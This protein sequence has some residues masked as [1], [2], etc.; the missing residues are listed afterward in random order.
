MKMPSKRYEVRFSTANT[1]VSVMKK[2][3]DLSQKSEEF[4]EKSLLDHRSGVVIR[5]ERW[6]VVGSLK[7][8]FD[9][10]LIHSSI[11]HVENDGSIDFSINQKIAVQESVKVSV[12]SRR[13]LGRK[14]LRCPGIEPRTSA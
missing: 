8:K 6:A 5:R 12:L 3:F 1:R 7:I 2:F 11:F 4:S 9:D 13:D 14:S 10:P